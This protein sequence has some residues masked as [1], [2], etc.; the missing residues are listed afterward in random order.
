MC[1]SCSIM[2]IVGRGGREE[3]LSSLRPG[4]RSELE[5]LGYQGN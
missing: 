2:I 1:N 4:G 5:K 3:S